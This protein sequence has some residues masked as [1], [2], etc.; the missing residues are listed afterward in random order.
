M[1]IED[2]ADSL[3]QPAK[4]RVY[5]QI[6][7]R[8]D[9]VIHVTGIVFALGATGWLLSHVAGSP[10][11]LSIAVY[12]FGLL[13]MIGM[14]AAYNLT[15]EHY[16][17]KDILRRLDHSAIYIM[18]AGT[19]TP[20]AAERMGAVGHWI[21]IA[22]WCAAGVGV[23]IKLIFPRRFEKVTLGLYL[24][25]GW[26]I[27]IALKPLIAH[28]GTRDLWLLLGGGLVYSAGVAFYLIER[29][30][31]HKSIWHAFVLVAAVLQFLSIVFEFT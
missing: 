2:T 14:S 15:P 8:S 11:F 13:A 27:V 1:S 19:Y 30:P 7:H 10:A 21:L 9:A 16:R 18:I 6:E 3:V 26:L 22:N 17:A 12:C 20:L 23:A 25:M 4:G 5:T 28:V 24:A 31:H 29:I